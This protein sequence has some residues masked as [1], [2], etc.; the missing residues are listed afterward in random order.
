[1]DEAR[2][3]LFIQLPWPKV[4]RKEGF[5][6]ESAMFIKVAHGDVLQKENMQN[7]ISDKCK[8]FFLFVV[9]FREVSSTLASTLGLEVRNLHLQLVTWISE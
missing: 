3:E 9:V 4:T 6:A 8:T 2:S 7:S 5:T 1:M